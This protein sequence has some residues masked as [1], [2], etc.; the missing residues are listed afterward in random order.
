MAIK[1]KLR[2]KSISGNRQSLYLDFYPSIPHPETGQLTRREFL[3][4]YIF[5]KP[6][7]EVDKL[8]NKNT[9]QFAEQIRQKKD[10][11]L[12]KPE[13]YTG[14]EKEKLRIKELGE[15]NFVE[16]FKILANKRKASNHDNWVSA[17]AYLQRF[18]NGNLKFIDLNESVCSDFRL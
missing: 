16:Y 12:N 15:R 10:S 2:Q 4:S 7:S 18:T 6:K 11:E 9:L 5:D 1:V 13:I 8:H 3:N 14:Y 17:Y